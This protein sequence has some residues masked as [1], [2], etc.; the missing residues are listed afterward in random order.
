TDIHPDRI[1][2]VA[3]AYSMAGPVYRAIAL[4]G[5]DIVAVAE[6]SDG[7]D[8]LVTGTTRVLD[9]RDLTILPAFADAHEH[10][11]ESAANAGLVPVDNAHSV[12]EFVDAIAR[13]ARVAEP[14]QWIQT[15]NA[16][17]ESNLAEHRLP[18]RTELDAA[19]SDHP[20]LARR[21]GHLAIVNSA[22]LRVAGI[23]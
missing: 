21:G 3:A 14:G 2:R 5:A 20:V 1:I 9:W 22:A 19:S 18:T 12:T 16:W 4:R 15:S 17:H 23:T 13:A 8:H 11:M 6:D 7:L 10:L